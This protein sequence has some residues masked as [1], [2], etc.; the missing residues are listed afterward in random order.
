MP[1]NDE[2]IRAA[3]GLSRF[4]RSSVDDIERYLEGLMIAAG[5]GNP[6]AARELERF[7]QALID[8]SYSFD[9][10]VSHIRIRGSVDAP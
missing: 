5:E 10:L 2:Y 9:N 7:R 8:L 4:S 1:V 3:G 6:D